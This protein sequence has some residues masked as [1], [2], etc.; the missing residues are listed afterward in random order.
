MAEYK[1]A[2]LSPPGCCFL[3]TQ[4][5][6]GDWER[7]DGSR[8]EWEA[9]FPSKPGWGSGQNSS[10]SVGS[11]AGPLSPSALECDRIPGEVGPP[12]SPAL[13]QSSRTHTPPGAA[14]LGEE[15]TSH[16]HEPSLGTLPCLPAGCN[17]GLSRSPMEQEATRPRLKVTS[18]QPDVGRPAHSQI[19][20]S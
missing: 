15:V 2:N 12:Q 13:A 17:P 18:H 20:F 10:A 5:P 1:L 11:T 4:A 19:L 7:G 3:D 8:E 6:L 9:D 14:H 16:D